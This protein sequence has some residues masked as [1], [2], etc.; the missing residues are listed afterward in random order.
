MARQ[1]PPLNA[2][3]VFESAARHLSFTRAA[4]ELNVTQAAVSHQIKTLEDRLGLSLFRRLNRSLLLTDEGQTLAPAVGEALGIITSAVDRLHRHDQSGSLTI[5][6]MDSFASIWMVPRM[7]GF[8]KRHPDIDVRILTS[9]T[10]VDMVRDNVDL[11]IRFGH[12]DYP[13]LH[14][15]WL[16]DE[17]VSPVCAPDIIT[18]QT[19][20]SK[21][22]DLRHHTLL[23]DDHHVSWEDWCERIG[24]KGFDATRGIS[25]QHSN[26]VLQAAIQG[27]GVALARSVLTADD[28][29]AGRL[30]KPFD[31]SLPSNFSYYL[32]C[33]EAN[34]RRP[35]VK[36]FRDWLLEEVAASVS[37]IEKQT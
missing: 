13:G 26:L 29:A 31:I 35:K 19:P 11:A 33:P 1:L 16:M 7:S 4:E 6:T 2:L 34:F 25:Y 9:D 28:L 10:I 24:V 21:P 30:V 12:G 18:K 20:L 17:T 15:E 8:R 23:H 5:T 14:V 3:R 37:L 22:E 27:D 36:A 32:A